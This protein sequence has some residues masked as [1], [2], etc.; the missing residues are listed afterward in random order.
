[1][2]V[3][4]LKMAM[5]AVVLLPVLAPM[6]A[7][8][9]TI[10][11]AMA[12]AY[13]NNPD[14]NA[15][16]AGLRATDEGVTIAKA[17][18]RPQ[19]NAF[20]QRTTTWYDNKGAFSG[21]QTI[22]NPNGIDRMSTISHQRGL[23]ITQQIFDGFQTLNNVRAAEATVFSERASVRAKEIQILLS[24][25]EAYSNIARDQQILAYRRQNVAFQ[26]EQIRAA[27]ERLA[28]GEGTRTDVSLAE[29]ELAR[30]LALV[31]SA[32]SQLKQSQAVYVQIVGDPPKGVKQAR[33]V[34]K[35]LPKTIDNAVATGWREHPRV[36]ATMH[37][38]DAAGF[39]VKS[40]EGAMLPGVV[41]QGQIQSTEGTQGLSSL[42]NYNSQSITARLNV[43][44]YQGGAEYG[45]IR[46]AKERLGQQ[47]ILLDSVRLDVQQT[48]V[49]AMAQ[50][51]A[52]LAA[53]KAGALQVKA[54]NDAL[55]SITEER[56]FGQAT[57]LEVLQ[58]QSN[59]LNARENL[60]VAQRDAV[61]SSFAILASIGRLTVATQDLK[62]AEYR[63]EVHYEKVKDAW[64]G[65]RTV[66]GR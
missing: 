23:T 35:S 33:P 3:F 30:A 61:V 2:R 62:V 56:R 37:A 50:Y 34:S 51:E 22:D 29:A 26:K 31:A 47:R 44:I 52:A 66:D 38:V 49:T 8:A 28:V 39:E 42:S 25:V 45:Q 21:T 14:L 10:F 17:G 58:V 6:P 4:K 1:M 54:S 53:T 60:A 32:D 41:V 16:R 55:A 24:A 12:K 48:V 63:P 19:V 5:L 13:E 7:V 36:L 59:V 20:A 15:A 9:D 43:P 11:D 65:L 18:W 57:T 46:Q 40:A 27:K 64:L